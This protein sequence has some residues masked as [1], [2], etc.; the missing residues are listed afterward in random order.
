VERRGI[1][2]NR[3]MYASSVV[4]V[5]VVRNELTKKY[6]GGDADGDKT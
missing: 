1:V 4:K 6:H 5:A 3:I 2:V